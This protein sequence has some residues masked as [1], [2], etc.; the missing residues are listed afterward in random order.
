MSRPVFLT[1]LIAVFANVG[2]G[3]DT[4]QWS[5]L[6]ILDWRILILAKYFS[7][8]PFSRKVL[9]AQHNHWSCFHHVSLIIHQHKFICPMKNH[10]LQREGARQ[11]EKCFIF[12]S[13]QHFPDLKR[14]FSPSTLE[15]FFQATQF[16]QIN[17]L[18]AANQAF[19]RWF[20]YFT[21][22]LINYI[23][24]VNLKLFTSTSLDFL[25]VVIFLWIS[26]YPWQ[27]FLHMIFEILIK[28]L[29]CF[30][31]CRVVQFF[32]WT[33]LNIKFQ[34]QFI[35]KCKITKDHVYRM[36]IVEGRWTMARSSS[37]RSK[38]F[39]GWHKSIVSSDWSDTMVWFGQIL[40]YLTIAIL[41]TWSLRS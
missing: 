29:S 23:H 39:I 30:N 13:A 20:L 3:A 16:N 4:G 21:L 14:N 41:Y 10:Q 6:M 28:I 26:W 2:A 31:R 33:S 8:L 34:S 36:V 40:L 22:T 9:F 17:F 12:I 37:F 5:H 7:T 1:L 15:T 38:L 11:N 25:F 32:T 24:W 27:R 35:Q 19:M 18:L